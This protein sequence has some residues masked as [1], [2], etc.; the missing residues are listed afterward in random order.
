MWR[1]RRTARSMILSNRRMFSQGPGDVVF[2]LFLVYW[3]L[4]SLMLINAVY[5]AGEW[6]EKFEKEK[7]KKE[8]FYVSKGV[9]QQVFCFVLVSIVLYRMIALA[10]NLGVGLEPRLLLKY[11]GLAESRGH[12]RE[13]ISM[14]P[15]SD[16]TFKWKPHSL[17][18]PKSHRCAHRWTW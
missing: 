6:L 15:S 13:Q 5:F 11:R 1:R 16:K 9:E 2:Y 3:V 12:F 4:F 18:A 14:V 17:A 8:I 7:T 10:L